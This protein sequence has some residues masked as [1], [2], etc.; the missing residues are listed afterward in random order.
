VDRASKCGTI[1][2]LRIAIS[3]H[4]GLSEVVFDTRPNTE[5]PIS[6]TDPLLSNLHTLPPSI[7]CQR[8]EDI[9]QSRFAALDL[10]NLHARLGQRGFHRFG[11]DLQADGP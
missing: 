10:L 5:Y 3:P 4:K 8:Q 2:I 9:L 6:N 7:L 1:P 11:L